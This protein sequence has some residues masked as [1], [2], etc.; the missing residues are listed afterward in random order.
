MYFNPKKKYFILFSK[1][2]NIS[3]ETGN[4]YYNYCY[5]CGIRCI[6]AANSIASIRGFCL[7]EEVSVGKCKQDTCKTQRLT[8]MINEK[9][10]KCQDVK[11][12]HNNQYLHN[13]TQI[14]I[15]R[16]LKRLMDYKFEKITSY[17]KGWRKIELKKKTCA[18]VQIF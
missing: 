18:L 5:K 17:L 12:T 2:N 4:I 10:C 15:Q 13:Q 11:L 3:T 9:F 1:N 7:G 16:H 14:H 8:K 6:I